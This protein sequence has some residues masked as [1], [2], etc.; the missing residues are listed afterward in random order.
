VTGAGQLPGEEQQ[1]QQ[2]EGEEGREEEA[3]LALAMSVDPAVAPVKAAIRYHSSR[4]LVVRL[5]DQSIYVAVREEEEEEE[6]GDEEEEE[7]EEEGEE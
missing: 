2:P 7:E 5:P 1:Q 4:F 6:G 3:A